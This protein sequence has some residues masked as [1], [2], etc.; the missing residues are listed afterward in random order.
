MVK[1]IKS[2]MSFNFK[3]GM[4]WL[5]ATGT[6]FLT[7]LLIIAIPMLSRDIVPNFMIGGIRIDDT[8][9]R[10]LVLAVFAVMAILIAIV[11]TIYN[12]TTRS[13]RG[14]KPFRIIIEIIILVFILIITL[15]AVKILLFLNFSLIKTN[16]LL[17]IYTF[18]IWGAQSFLTVVTLGW[19]HFRKERNK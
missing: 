1:K 19:Y 5:V 6:I 3:L 17:I 11:G 14:A 16:L 7:A 15:I 2:G 8:L 4:I 18:V 9:W 12:L 13:A 10:L